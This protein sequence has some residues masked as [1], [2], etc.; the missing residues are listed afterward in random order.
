MMFEHAFMFKAETERSRDIR[1]IDE[2]FFLVYS[3]RR[4]KEKIVYH[5]PTQSPP[6][7]PPSVDEDARK[8]LDHGT[9]SKHRP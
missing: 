3:S 2:V 5:A 1:Y 6:D 4:K 9:E 8:P 7:K